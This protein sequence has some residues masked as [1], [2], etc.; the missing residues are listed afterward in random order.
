MLGLNFLYFKITHNQ[1][2]YES[3]KSIIVSLSVYNTYAYI[4]F[5][6]M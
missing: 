5:I 4:R 1:H 3:E 2:T 6:E